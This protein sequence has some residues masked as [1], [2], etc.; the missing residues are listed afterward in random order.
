MI[1]FPKVGRDYWFVMDWW[2][3]F[4]AVPVMII[5]KRGILPFRPQIRISLYDSLLY[6]AYRNDDENE[7][8]PAAIQTVKRSELF[9]TQAQAQKAAA[10]K[11]KKL[12]EARQRED[13]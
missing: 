1:L 11:N 10:Q 6:P 13:Y 7:D 3:Q 8:A 9:K 2:E 4:Y 12:R 5:R